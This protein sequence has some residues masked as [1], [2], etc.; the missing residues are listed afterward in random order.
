MHSSLIPSILLVLGLLATPAAAAPKSRVKERGHLTLNVTLTATLD[1]PAGA[2]GSGTI[3]VDKP[4]FKS[5]ETASLSLTTSGL[6]TG[7]YS[8]DATLDDATTAHLGDFAVDT[9]VPPAAGGDPLVFAISDTLDTAK[10]ASISVSNST[11]IV[12]LQ[13]EVVPGMATWKYIA[14]VQVTAP[15]VLVTTNEHG[16]K[17]KHVH[18]HIVSHSFVTDNVES[19]RHFVCVAFGA[20]KD[21]ELTINVDG[22][23]VGTVMSTKQG[24]VDL[25]DIAETVV[26]RDVELITL[27]DSL[28]AV[29]MEAKF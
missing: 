28:G 18:G 4:K 21:T 8:V 25:H 13:G 15:E 6:T 9:A 27:T 12:M 20:P 26:L 29:I 14:N 17:P 3:E 5:A 22:T 23:P 1:A 16:P 24:K 11:A 7:T 10:I 2:T 19:H